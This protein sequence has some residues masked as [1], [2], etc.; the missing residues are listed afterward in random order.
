MWVSTISS[1][2]RLLACTTGPYSVTAFCNKAIVSCSWAS[3]LLLFLAYKVMALAGTAEL[4]CDKKLMLEE[5]LA[6]S[7]EMLETSLL[8]ISSKL[9]NKKCE[10]QLKIRLEQNEAIHQLH[11]LDKNLG[12][13]V[14]G[15]WQFLVIGQHV[16]QRC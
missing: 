9:R 13:V 12:N 11:H 1:A 16:I 10:K 15:V 2:P 6:K 3:K 7:E 14:T 8:I 5:A 4:F